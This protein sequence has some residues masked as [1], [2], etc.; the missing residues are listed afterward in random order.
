MTRLAISALFA[1]A[2]VA[3]QADKT[4]WL[5]ELDTDGMSTGWGSVAVRRSVEGNPLSLRGTDHERGIGTHTDSSFEL[6]VTGEALS[7][8]AVVGVDAEVGDDGT[9]RGSVRFAVLAD[10]ITVAESPVMRSDSKPHVLHADLRG[11]KF[12]ELIADS[13]G[14]NIDFDHADWC[15]ARFTLKDGSSISPDVPP[16]EQLAILTPKPSAAPRINGPRVYGVRPGRPVLFRLPVSGERPLSLS[17]EGLP[18]GL[19]FDGAKGILS[20]LIEEPS[21]YAITFKA[22]NSRGADERMFTVRV[23]D[24]IALTPPM[25]WNSWNCFAGRVTDKDIR[26]AADVLDKSE[27][28]NHGWAYVNIDDFWQNSVNKTDDPTLNGPQRNPDGSIA[29]NARFPSMKEL[30]D[31]VHSKG[32][33]IGLYSSPGPWTCGGCAGSWKHEWQDAATYAEWGYDY[34]KYDWCGYS[35]VDS[36]VRRENDISRLSLPY[37]LMGEA[38][39]AQKRDIVYSL[40]QYGMGNVS[41]WGEN[42]GG[43]CWRTTGDIIDTWGSVVT[44]LAAQSELWHFARPGAWNDPDMLVVGPLGWGNIHPSRLTRNEQYT[45]VSF[46]CVLCSPLLIGCDLTQIDDFTMSLLTNDEVLET[47][48]DPLGAAAARVAVDSWTETWVKPMSDGSFVFALLNKSRRTRPV[49]AEFAHLG[50][51]GEWRVRDLWRQKDVGLCTG[52]WGT[53]VP[54]HATT[55]IRAFPAGEDSRL[56][57]ALRDI[58]DNATYMQFEKVR[59]VDKPGL[60]KAADCGGCEMR[61]RAK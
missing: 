16:E 11:A 35:S 49:A 7:F 45:H 23:G 27:L 14:D 12:V 60:H 57:P 34:L 50:M 41:T 3:A 29:P 22:S 58:R 19:S 31:Y 61:G 9:P 33:K 4:I 32:L 10:G 26:G 44:I 56:S 21:D 13:T 17:A 55:L 43:N 40:C 53:E 5:D 52:R 1:A 8:D 24:K 42:A 2:A 38:L 25:G 6:A 54:P 39:A 46:W 37:R 59:R 15:D 47:N 20:G 48:Q 28:A 30:A 36:K 18:R 51:E